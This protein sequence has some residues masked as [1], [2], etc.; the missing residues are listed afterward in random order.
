MNLGTSLV[1]TL[2]IG[3]AALGAWRR[4][5]LDDDARFIAIFAAVLVANAAI[6][7][8]YTKDETMIPAGIFYALAAYAGV[9]TLLAAD[10]SPRGLAAAVLTTVLVVTS[11]GWTVRAAGLPYF[12]RAQA[13]KQRGDW[14]ELPGQWRRAGRW[15]EDSRS[16][17]HGPSVARR[18]AGDD[19]SQPALRTPMA[20]PSLG[21][22]SR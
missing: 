17:R 21:R 12:L 18:G 3:V 19:G 4:R 5:A 13:F 11:V 20:E 22:V 16:R 10:Y 1:T 6:S 7:F 15:P 2:V 9:R 14:A 8:P